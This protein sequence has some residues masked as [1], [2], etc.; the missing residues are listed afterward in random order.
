[1]VTKKSKYHTKTVKFGTKELI[2]YSLDGVTWSTRKTELLAIKERHDTERQNFAQLRGVAGEAEEEK[3]V[4]AA[5]ETDTKA[6]EQEGSHEADEDTKV[7]TPGRPAKK[8]IAKTPPPRTP[9][10]RAA[11]EK[12]APMAKGSK[13][14]P[15]VKGVLAKKRIS[16]AP[17]QKGSRARQKAA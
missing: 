17:A 11:A 3:P 7:K 12:E 15:A 14:K 16:S 5:E 10:H 13:V 9:P 6:E 2:L 4:E 8:P 1:M